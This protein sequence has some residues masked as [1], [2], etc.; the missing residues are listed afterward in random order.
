MLEKR[1][2]EVTY[3]L[4]WEDIVNNIKETD[5]YKKNKNKKKYLKRL[6]IKFI[7]KHLNNTSTDSL[8]NYSKEIKKIY[9]EFKREYKKVF[10][11]SIFYQTCKKL[12]K[13]SKIKNE[14]NYQASC[15]LVKTFLR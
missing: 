2:K 12:K 14:I 3:D 15:S 1:L 6:K 13:T 7:K 9:M 5:S 11:D 10:K 8:S 4:T